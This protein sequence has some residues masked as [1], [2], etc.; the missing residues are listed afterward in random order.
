MKRMKGSFFSFGGKESIRRRASSVLP[1]CSIDSSSAIIFSFGGGG[2]LR[3][4]TGADMGNWEW[5]EG[6]LFLWDMGL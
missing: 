6:C 2:A 5:D 1:S 3:A 4:F